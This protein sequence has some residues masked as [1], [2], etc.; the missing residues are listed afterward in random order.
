MHKNLVK[1]ARVVPEVSSGTER[2]T[3]RHTHQS[4][5][6]ATA[7]AGEV[8]KDVNLTFCRVV[9]I[10]L[11]RYTGSAGVLV[12]HPLD[13]IKVCRNDHTSAYSQ[14]ANQPL[15]AKRV[16]SVESVQ[17]SLNGH[18]MRTSLATTLHVMLNVE[19]V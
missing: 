12:G 18:Q 3:D 17:D 11:V 4:Q 13:T 6:F 2:P 16:N 1:I 15:I 8:I 14:I 9:V 5:Y 10:V 19:L 7:P